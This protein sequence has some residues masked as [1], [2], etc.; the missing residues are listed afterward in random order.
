MTKDEIRKEVRKKRLNVSYEEKVHENAKVTEKLLSL[1]VVKN[2]KSIHVYI[3]QDGELSTKDFI[4]GL[5][6]KN[7]Y[8]PNNDDRKNVSHRKLS[9]VNGE[10]ILSSEVYF[11]IG[12]DVII[13]PGIAFTTDGSRLGYG[14]GYYDKFLFES[15]S[16]KIGICYSCQLVYSLPVEDHD[17]DMDDVVFFLLD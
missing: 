7:I 17:V 6:N 1:S 2:A 12:F 10:I 14:G 5:K 8:T 9:I 11:D 13:C 3:S 4:L 15:K 16:Y